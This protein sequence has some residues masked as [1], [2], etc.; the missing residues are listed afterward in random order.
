MT[1]ILEFSSVESSVSCENLKTLCLLKKPDRKPQHIIIILNMLK[2]NQE[3]V[4]KVNLLL[5]H[6]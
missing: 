6:N 5:I 2:K 3:F 4:F 1:E